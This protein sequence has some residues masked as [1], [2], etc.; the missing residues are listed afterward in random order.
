[1]IENNTEIKDNSQLLKEIL[2]E[3]TLHNPSVLSA[4]VVSDDGLNVSSGIPH[5]DDDSIALIAS[6]LV[7][8]A[9]TF[10]QRLEQGQINRILLEGE[11][12]TTVVLGAGKRTVLVVLIPANEKLGLMSLAMRKAADQIAELFG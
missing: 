12:R 7:D 8:T 6:D 1:M 3:L 5:I 4:L 9:K 2:N 11:R 10:G